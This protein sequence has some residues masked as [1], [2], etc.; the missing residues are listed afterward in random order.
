M[1]SLMPVSASGSTSLA[2]PGSMPLTKIEALPAAAAARTGPDISGGTTPS[3]NCRKTGL[4]ETT[5]APVRRMR[6]RSSRASMMRTS[7]IAV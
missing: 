5:L 4:L 3:G 2:N 7:A 6:A 1:R